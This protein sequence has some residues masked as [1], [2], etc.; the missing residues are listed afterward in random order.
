[1]DSV[2][3]LFRRPAYIEVVESLAL[4]AAAPQVLYEGPYPTAPLADGGWP[5]RF[6]VEMTVDVWNPA[7][8][9]AAAAAGP[10]TV[11]AAGAWGGAGA[12][13]ASVTLEA[14]PA[15]G[16]TAVVVLNLTATAADVALW[17]PLGLGD[18]P[19]YEVTT[20]EEGWGPV[21]RLPLSSAHTTPLA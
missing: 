19:L 13:V 18:Q 17:W 15:G 11:R 9:G 6:V 20:P 8:A 5:G 21:C 2:L 4:T 12:A 1:M 7:P 3:V 16:E 14:A 10:V